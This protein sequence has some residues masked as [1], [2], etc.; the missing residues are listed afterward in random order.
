[1]KPAWARKIPHVM[2]LS[3]RAFS[4]HGVFSKFFIAIK[5]MDWNT[6]TKRLRSSPATYSSF[7]DPPDPF[8]LLARRRHFLAREGLFKNPFFGGLIRK[9][10]SH[11]VSGD[12]SDIG[13][14]KLICQL[15]AEGKKIILFP[16][17]KRGDT[18]ALDTLKPGIAMLVSRSKS[19]VVPAYIYGTFSTW[20]RFRKLPKL[21]GQRTACVFG[22]P[23]LWK[24]FEHLDKKEAQKALTAKL[25]ESINA[26]RDWYEK[27]T[28]ALRLN[29]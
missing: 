12:A 16:E 3:S 13:V 27:G 22:S 19:A 8:H 18:D 26:L 25:T 10:N 6:T 17:G 14:F 11:P 15:L 4:S 5:C 23:I 7:Y 24:Q 9:L 21:F 20:N 28:K 29:S 1:M 2:A